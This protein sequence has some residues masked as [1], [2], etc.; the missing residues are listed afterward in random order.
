LIIASGIF[1]FVVGDLSD[2]IQKLSAFLNAGGYLLITGQFSEHEGKSPNNMLGWLPGFLD[3]VPLPPS[4]QKMSQALSRA[5]LNATST[6]ED[7]LFEGLIYQ[8]ASPIPAVFPDD[9]VQSF[10]ELTEQTANS[11]IN[12]LDFVGD[13]L[14]FYRGEIHMIKMIG[15]FPGI[16]SA[17]LARKFGI[18][19]PVV[20]K[21][22][23]KLTEREF[24]TK[25][26]DTEDKKRYRLYLTEKGWT[27]YRYHEKYHKA[28][29]QQLFDFLV[30]IPSCQLSTVKEFLDHAI[31]LIHN[32]A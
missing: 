18:T 15:D 14:T 16:Y 10:I 3:G 2:F 19:R 9:V 27:A 22:L 5:G 6:F 4:E 11:K 28:N 20:H 17:E 12:F 25:E 29:D 24:I 7:A 13:D 23:Q 26:D 30:N 21:T 31:T 1:N 8:K 32:H